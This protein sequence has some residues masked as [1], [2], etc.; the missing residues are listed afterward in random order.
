MVQLPQNFQTLSA[1]MQKIKLPLLVVTST[2]S[3]IGVAYGADDGSTIVKS[4][5]GEFVT[6]IKNDGKTTVNAGIM[7]A[8]GAGCMMTRH[9]VP[10]GIGILSLTIFNTAMKFV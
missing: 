3:L 8:S 2:I 7:L 6:L 4:I 9:W 1:T 10:A 5:L